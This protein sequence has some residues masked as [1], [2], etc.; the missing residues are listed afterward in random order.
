MKPNPILKKL[1]FSETDR[2]VIIHTDDVGM[3]QASVQAFI[4][5]WEFGT[6]SSGAIMVPCPW[7]KAAADYCKSHPT[8]DMGVHATV[9]AEWDTYRWRPLSTRD[10]ATGLIDDEGF[11]WQ[12]SGDA[13]A[14]ADAEAVQTEIQAQ[15]Q[16]ALDWGVPVTHVDTHMGTVA[17]AKFI[18]AYL[19]VAVQYHI[20]PMLPRT[21]GTLFGSM[22]MGSG[23]TQDLNAFTE[24]LEAQGLPLV[25]AILMMPLDKPEGQVETAKKLLSEVPVG[26]THLLFHPA[27]DTPELRAACPDWPSRVANYK[28]FMSKE[29][30]EYI[31]TCGIHVIGYRDIKNTMTF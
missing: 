21:G 26:V 30:K 23:Q 2:L 15:V 10:P 5:L 31:K 6:I 20:P 8:V 22:G 11:M 14:R 19:Q 18:P 4:D 13:Q 1:G 3:C 27:V 7:A 25:D 17:H 24:Q 12:H 16:R 29:V 9:N 28:T